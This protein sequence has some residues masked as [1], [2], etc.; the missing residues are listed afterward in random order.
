MYFFEARGLEQVQTLVQSAANGGF[1]PEVIDA[2]ACTF[3]QEGREAAVHRA[4]KP[5]NAAT[6]LTAAVSP[7]YR[8][9]ATPQKLGITTLKYQWSRSKLK[10]AGSRRSA[11]RGRLCSNAKFVL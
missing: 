7:L 9:P 1:E 8:Y 3:L 4:V 10:Y 6:C 2:A 5:K 11:F